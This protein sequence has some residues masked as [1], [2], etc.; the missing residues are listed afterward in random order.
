MSCTRQLDRNAL[1]PQGVS[2]PL[3]VASH[4]RDFRP[5]GPQIEILKQTL[6]FVPAE[7][8]RRFAGALGNIRA[9]GRQCTPARGGGSNPAP[10]IRLSAASFEDS[11]NQSINVTALH[12]FGHVVD[13][14]YGA[15]AGLQTR[16][17]DLYRLL[18]RTPHTGHT[19]GSGETFA[20]CYLIFVITQLARRTYR[21][22]ADPRAYEGEEATHRFE[23]LINSPA[24]DNWTGAL[25]QLRRR[26]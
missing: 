25:S 8:L 16:H 23:A 9:S 20:D 1:A 7:H 6:S 18:S 2:I 4:D 13:Y 10:W 15:M 24:F 3:Y 22:P 5:T 11:L 21:H 26:T 14:Q 12:E 17:P 19:Q